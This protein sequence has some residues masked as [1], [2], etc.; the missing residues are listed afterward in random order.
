LHVSGCLQLKAFQLHLQGT[1]KRQER[2]PLELVQ[3][4]DPHA[5][6]TLVRLG[7]L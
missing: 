2:A 5:C 6:S 7:D 3:T 1:C 4:P